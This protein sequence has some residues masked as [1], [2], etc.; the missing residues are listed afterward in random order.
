MQTPQCFFANN[1]SLA[2]GCIPAEE[3]FLFCLFPSTCY[4]GD[5]V[6]RETQTSTRRQYPQKCTRHT[7]GDEMVGNQS[8]W[9][10]NGALCQSIAFRLHSLFNRVVKSFI[11]NMLKFRAI[12]QREILQEEKLRKVEMSWQR[13]FFLTQRIC[14]A[15]QYSKE[16][17]YTI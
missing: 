17:Q 15:L 11:L 6:T 13:D 3:R 7:L 5:W 9:M 14:L 1:C 16:I 2:Q 12:W 8:S 4:L 10:C